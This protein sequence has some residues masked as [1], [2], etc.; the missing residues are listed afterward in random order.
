L[1]LHAL[2]HGLTR[3]LARELA[4]ELAR[5]LHL[6]TWFHWYDAMPYRKDLNVLP[7]FPKVG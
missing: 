7:V 3:E 1:C 2:H 4:Q 6:I 5:E